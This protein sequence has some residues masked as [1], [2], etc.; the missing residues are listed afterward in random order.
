MPGNVAEW[1]Y[2]ECSMGSKKMK[3]GILTFFGQNYGAV[4]QA[5]ALRQV[6]RETTGNDVEVINFRMREAL[7]RG[8]TKLSS[9]GNGDSPEAA[10]ARE[11]Y[12]MFEDESKRLLRLSSDHLYSDSIDDFAQFVAGKYDVIIVGSDEVWVVDKYKV[13]PTPFWL[14]IDLDCRMLSYAVSSRSDM[15]KCPPE[16]LSKIGRCLSG[17][18]YLGVRDVVTKEMAEQLT[19]REVH[20]NCD[21]TFA[22]RFHI[23]KELGKWLLKIRFKITGKRKC[24]GLATENGW[25]INSVTEKFSQVFD[26]VSLYNYSCQLQCN[27]VL[28]PLEWIQAIAGCD[29]IITTFFHGTVFALKGNVPFISFE[30]RQISDDRF[31]KIYDL[32]SRHGLEDH[33]HRLTNIEEQS[34]REIGT[35]L[36]DVLAGKTENDFDSICKSESERFLPFLAELPDVRPNHQIIYRKEDCCGCGACVDACHQRAI[37]LK[38]DDRGFWYPVVDAG[39][40][41]ECG[42]CKEACSFQRD[43]KGIGF[44][45]NLGKPLELYGVKHKDEEIR[46]KSRSGGIFT[47][48]TDEILDGGGSVYGASFTKEFSVKHTRATTKDERDKFRGSKYVQSA[49]GDIFEQIRVDL[50]NGRNVAFSGTPCQVAAVRKDL[51]NEDD[52][53][54]YFIDV[55]C[56]GVPSPM[57]WKDYLLYLKDEHGGNIEA[58]NFRDKKFGWNSHRETFVIN[59]KQYDSDAYAFLFSSQNIMRP[60]CHD[61]PYK[62]SIRV[63]DITI[64]DFWHIDKAISGFD[65]D[66]GVSLVI[67]NTE[68]GQ[69]LFEK[70]KDKVDWK[71]TTLNDCMQNSMRFSY[72]EPRGVDDFWEEYRKTGMSGCIQRRMQQIKEENRYRNEQEKRLRRLQWKNGIKRVLGKIWR[73]AFGD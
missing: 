66:K 13:F 47:A 34:L 3:I 59:G 42:L 67:V 20:L 18:S 19:G 60:S 70:C 32:L 33:Y 41:L 24:I 30:E 29:G 14:P 64:A 46:A 50:K 1:V 23:N 57:V 62:S 21:P 43:K 45:A 53:G 22:Y 37:K 40:C 68:K 55:M 61:C 8:K 10:F 63:G 52:K 7:E 72:P 2:P 6:I 25:L 4:L 35:F 51:E 73:T 71:S 11:R 58:F 28:T 54:L 69:A 16:L 39:A 31:S 27:T 15:T 44:L 36:A 17:F 26:F 38:S 5:Y 65:D 9:V 12:E 48:L 49:M 56:L